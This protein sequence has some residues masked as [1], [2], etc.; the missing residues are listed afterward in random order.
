MN[1]N[2][3]RWSSTV[4]ATR[5]GKIPNAAW[6]GYLTPTTLVNASAVY[7]VT[8]R[9]TVSV[10]VNNV[11]NKIKHDTTGGWPNYPVGSYS[12]AGRAGWVELNYHFGS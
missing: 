1:W 11:A 10:I 3:G 9:L 4:F 2:V 6:T 12:P 5:Y 8:D 7:Q